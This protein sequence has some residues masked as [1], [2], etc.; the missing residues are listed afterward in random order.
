MSE[1]RGKFVVENYLG[2]SISGQAQHVLSDSN[3]HS[4]LL[5][6]SNLAHNGRTAEIPFTTANGHGDHWVLSFVVN[7]RL[8]VV[9][10]KCDYET[11]DSPNTLILR[12]TPD[13]NDIELKVICPSSGDCSTTVEF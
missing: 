4:A 5:G 11:K 7:E 10:K 13:G 1:Y 9:A 6:F 2:V 3:I 8:F 12:I